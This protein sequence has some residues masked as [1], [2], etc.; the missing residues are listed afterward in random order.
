MRE[1][2]ALHSLQSLYD[3][4]NTI[5]LLYPAYTIKLARRAGYMLAGRA[6]SMFARS[7][8]QGIIDP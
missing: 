4:S 3:P 2:F 6:R 5:A 7:G 8:K 1:K